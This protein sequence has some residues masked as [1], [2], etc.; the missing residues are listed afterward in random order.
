LHRAAR[1]LEKLSGVALYERASQGI[2]LT[3]SAEVFQRQVQLAFSELDQGIEEIGNYLGADVGEIT[4]GTMP[5]ARS[6]V[7]PRALTLFTT[8]RPDVK[9][10]V[11]EGPYG[12]LLRGLRYGETDLLIGALRAD[13]PVDDV[14]QEVL[15]SDPLAVVARAGHPLAQRDGISVTDLAE[16]SWVIPR[17][18]TPTRTYFDQLFD[19]HRVEPPNR[20][21]EAGSLILIRGLLADSDRLTVMSAHQ[22]RRE[23]ETGVLIRLNFDL[24]DTVRDIGLTTRRDWHP[25]LSQSLF[26]DHLRAVTA[27]IPSGGYSKN[28]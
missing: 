7:L 18:E 24:S 1:D 21:I 4:I 13:L 25:T 15:F 22:M 9:V 16:H 14:V 27:A 26:M 12:G 20:I 11:V 28:E 3:R 8:A 10:R 5:L 23:E 17:S 2:V 19:R 6:F